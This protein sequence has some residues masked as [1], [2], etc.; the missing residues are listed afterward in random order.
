MT[1]APDATGAS[2]AC[3]YN[4]TFTWANFTG[5]ART[6]TIIAKETPSGGTKV[7][8]TL[9]WSANGQQERSV[10]EQDL[11]RDFS[12]RWLDRRYH[13]RIT[14]TTTTRSVKPTATNWANRARPLNLRTTSGTT[15]NGT[16][17]K[18]PSART[19]PRLNGA[20]FTTSATA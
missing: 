7:T 20:M 15:T 19:P 13:A 2:G 8:Q 18:A 12:D 16:A 1:N 6:D 17:Q 11:I 9:T 5:A 3:T 4:L 14:P 10:G